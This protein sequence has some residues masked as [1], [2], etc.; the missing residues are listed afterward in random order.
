MK[1]SCITFRKLKKVCLFN[2]ETLVSN[3]DDVADLWS[4]LKI[5]HNRCEHPKHL[6]NRELYYIVEQYKATCCERLCP[7]VGR[8]NA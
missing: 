6:M 3:C 4:Q 8:K 1:N 7:V 5:P 2:P